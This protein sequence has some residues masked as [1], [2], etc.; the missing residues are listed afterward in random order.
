MKQKVLVGFIMDG[1]SGGID[2]YL[3]NFLN[4]VWNDEIQI[5]FLSNE[6]NQELVEYLEKYHSKVLPISNLRHPISQFRQVRS[7]I[8]TEGYDIVYLNISTAIDC[9]AALAAKSCGVKRILLHSHSS[10]NDCESVWKRKIM[11]FIHF[12]CRRFLFSFGTEFYGCSKKAG[13]W[14]FPKKIVNSQR[15]RTVFNAVDLSKFLFRENI[16]KEV[17]KEFGIEGKFVIGHVGNFCYQKNHYFLLDVFEEVQKRCP[18]AVLFLV[19]R[20]MRYEAVQ[21]RVIQ[22]GLQKKVILTG[23]RNDVPRLLQGMDFFLLPSNFEGLPTVGVEAQCSGLPCLMSATVTEEVKIT[24]KC[25]FLPLTISEKRW[26][27]F[28]LDHKNSERGELEWVGNKE[29]Y[30]LE[31]LKKQQRKMIF[32]IENGERGF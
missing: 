6:R 17:R 31:H 4:N 9:I 16:R 11:D 30:S 12:L 18:E 25:W 14:L 5:D 32:G 22:K 24:N 23:L 28:I 2:R 8:Q 29:N 20:G 26:A 10:G 1:K 15:F 27:K 3:L 13:E 21:E 19:G 7:L